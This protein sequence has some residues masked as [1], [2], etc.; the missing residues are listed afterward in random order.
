MKTITYNEQTHRLVPVEII[1]RLNAQLKEAQEAAEFNFQQY[2]DAG[3]LL[4]EAQ[5]EIEDLSYRIRQQSEVHF[6]EEEEFRKQIQMLT[7]TTALESMVQK[8]GEVMR[9][10]AAKG[11]EKEAVQIVVDGREERAY[12]NAVADCA[13]AIRAIPGVTLEDLK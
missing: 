9:E 6:Y 1:D 11:V 10:R 3:R 8:A 12:N 7:D 2:Q 4:C 13:N 5:N